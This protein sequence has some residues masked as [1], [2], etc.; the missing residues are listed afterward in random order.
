MVAVSASQAIAVGLPAVLLILG[1]LIV[2][3][4]P[5]QATIRTIGIKTGRWAGSLRLRWRSLFRSRPSE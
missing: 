2:I 4:L 5:G 3:L 1:G